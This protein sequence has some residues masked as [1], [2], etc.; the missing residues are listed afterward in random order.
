[1]LDVWVCVLVSSV[2]L[3]EQVGG[4]SVGVE[5]GVRSI[6]GT[7]SLRHVAEGICDC[8]SSQG[9]AIWRRESCAVLGG[10][11]SVSDELGEG[12]HDDVAL[13]SAEV[14]EVDVVLQSDLGAEVSEIDHLHQI[15][16]QLEI[17]GNTLRKLIP[18]KPFFLVKT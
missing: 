15:S 5:A 8:A 4:S 3:L 13:P 6:R 11:K 1:M 9:F 10:E 16:F 14:V 2:L 7:K 12:G 18:R 17:S